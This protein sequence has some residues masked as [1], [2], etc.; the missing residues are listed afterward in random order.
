MR[1]K[2][3]KKVFPAV[4]FGITCEFDITKVLSLSF[5]HLKTYRQHRQAPRGSEIQIQTSVL[6]LRL[7]REEIFPCQSVRYAEKKGYQF[8]RNKG[9]LHFGKAQLVL[10]IESI[11]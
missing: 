3:E 9:L 11:G 10:R 2:R 1:E 4:Y 8:M 6:V 5:F 7:S